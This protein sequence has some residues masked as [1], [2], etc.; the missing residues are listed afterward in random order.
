MQKLVIATLLL[1]L[2]S[3]ICM[4]SE[5]EDQAASFFKIYSSLCL[6]NLFKLE[7]LRETLKPM[8]KLPPDKAELFLAG[9]SG[10][11]WPVPDKYA[12][13]VLALLSGKSFCAVYVRKADT[14][15]AIKMFTSMAASAPFPIKVKLLKNETTQTIVNGQ[16]QTISYEW[17]APNAKRGMMFT[18]TTASADYAQI[19][20]LGSAAVVRLR[21]SPEILKDINK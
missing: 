19:Q 15:A 4:A 17:S 21:Y 8:P 14:A 7:E 6:K 18:L 10:D 11:A 16:T 9:K 12:T 5:G 2:A 3:N 13:A 1:A 20:V